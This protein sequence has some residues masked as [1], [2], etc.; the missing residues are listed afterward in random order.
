MPTR[1]SL[2][3][4]FSSLADDY[5]LETLASGSLT[6][7]A[8]GIA[9][10]EVDRRGLAHPRPA[11]AAAADSE[12]EALEEEDTALVTVARSL[13]GHRLEI[14]RAR[15][16]AEGIPAFVM[17]G[18]T[19]QAYSLIAIAMGGARLQVPRRHEAEARQLIALIQS[20]ALAANPRDVETHS[21]GG[22]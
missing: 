14:L 13:T 1:E 6:A 20:G 16:V 2:V 17:D 4:Y 10:A 3:E 5:L 22:E 12:P 8:A 7:V 19:N 9:G 18:N 15:L 11:A 21:A